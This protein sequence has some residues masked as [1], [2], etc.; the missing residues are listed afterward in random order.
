MALSIDTTTSIDSVPGLTALREKIVPPAAALC[1]VEGFGLYRYAADVAGD[2]APFIVVPDSA[3]AQGRW[4]LDAVPAISDPAVRARLGLGT[5]ATAS[6]ETADDEARLARHAGGGT[7]ARLLAWAARARA[8][9]RATGGGDRLAYDHLAHGPLDLS[10]VEALDP[11]G[12][13]IRALTG[14]AAQA[15]ALAC[16]GSDADL[17]G[18]WY[19]VDPGQDVLAGTD[20][21]KSTAF[22]AAH[23]DLAPGDLVVLRRGT[24]RMCKPIG[25]MNA[26]KGVRDGIIHCEH[27]WLYE[28]IHDAAGAQ[29]Q[30][31]GYPASDNA[32]VALVSPRRVSFASPLTLSFDRTP[33]DPQGTGEADKKIPIGMNAWLPAWSEIRVRALGTTG[34]GVNVF[35]GYATHVELWAAGCTSRNLDDGTIGTV[36]GGRNVRVYLHAGAGRHV[37]GSGGHEK[38]G[39]AIWRFGGEAQGGRSNAALD[40]HGDVLELLVEPGTVLSGGDVQDPN[41]ADGQTVRP[42]GAVIGAYRWRAP[43]L[44]CRKVSSAVTLRDAEYI[45]LVE[46]GVV[47]LEDCDHGYR[48]NQGTPGPVVHLARIGAIRGSLRSTWVPATATEQARWNVGHAVSLLRDTVHR[49]EVGDVD[50]TGGAALYVSGA[51]IFP[52]PTHLR[53]GR[54]RCRRL[55]RRPAA[56]RSSDASDGSRSPA[57]PSRMLF[58][59]RN[60]N[61]RVKGLRME[62]F[63]AEGYDAA[64]VVG[65]GMD[66]VEFGEVEWRN[67]FINA[68]L[69][70]NVATVVLGRGE[71]AAPTQAASTYGYIEC[72]ADD[73]AGHTVTIGTLY[74]SPELRFT[75]EH[76]YIFGREGKVGTIVGTPARLP[77]GFG[78]FGCRSG[79][80]D[81][82]DRSEIWVRSGALTSPGEVWVWQ[83]PGSHLDPGHTLAGFP[84]GTRVTDRTTGTTYAK[85]GGTWSAV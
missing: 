36:I 47:E 69:S 72:D 23:P 7:T 82:G 79:F 22:L 38:V 27:P 53:L 46:A 21:L 26:V 43:H 34:S 74:L 71:I 75:G 64:L 29:T 62:S 24:T 31:G 65:T 48:Q 66:H 50:V 33:F 8:L 55:H 1:W 4:V 68:F 45:H 19:P 73:A 77:A 84:E 76:R 42:G 70:A 80:M 51:V 2:E 52:D 11:A 35:G 57:S 18:T 78:G 67:N 6:L 5:A 85:S 49:L 39:L 41:A 61:P 12:L 83:A 54:V 3:P 25:E 32:E 37:V 44:I 40:T 17:P 60:L 15:N 58:G 30:P 59:I 63:L 28:G 13:E 14:D 56:D 16:I 10:G 9:G 20:R 81:A